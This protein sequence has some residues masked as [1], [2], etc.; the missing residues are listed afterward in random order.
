MCVG[1]PM[2]VVQVFEGSALCQHKNETQTIDTLL[3]GN[4]KVGEWVL[5]FLGCAR[6]IIS[7]ERAE[8][9]QDALLALELAMSGNH[10]IDHLF[11]DLVDREPQLPD[12]LQTNNKNTGD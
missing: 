5:T 7:E 11:Q 8:Q 9:I 12:F 6:E 10:D 1:I 4:P 3:V 2:K